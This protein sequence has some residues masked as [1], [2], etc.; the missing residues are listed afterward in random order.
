MSDEPTFS[1]EALAAVKREFELA[2]H[3]NAVADKPAQDRQAQ[4]I[5]YK[6]KTAAVFRAILACPGAVTL[7]LHRKHI[8]VTA[9]GCQGGVHIPCALFRK[10]VMEGFGL[11]LLQRGIIRERL[12]ECGLVDTVLDSIKPKKGPRPKCRRQRY[13]RSAP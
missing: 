7:A 12:Q 9:Q 1:A 8:L 5:A 10:S 13:H 2:L 11:G 6:G 4:M 3:H